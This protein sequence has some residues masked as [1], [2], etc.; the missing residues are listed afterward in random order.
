MYNDL[1]DKEGAV[2]VDRMSRL[3]PS[4]AKFFFPHSFLLKLN[5]SFLIIH[6]SIVLVLWPFRLETV[7][8]G[9]G[10]ILVLLTLSLIFIQLE[11]IAGILFDEQSGL[12]SNESALTSLVLLLINL[13]GLLPKKSLTTSVN[14]PFLL[15]F[16]LMALLLTLQLKRAISSAS[17]FPLI[18]PWTI[19]AFLL[20]H[21]LL[22]GVL[23]LC[24]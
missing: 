16:D 17:Y 15:L 7:P 4:S 1:K 13:S 22:S 14:L 12:L 2:I 11:I 24:L 8:I 6:G 10:K 18:Q 20:L 23:C 9:G 5:L 3:I 19:L 21:L